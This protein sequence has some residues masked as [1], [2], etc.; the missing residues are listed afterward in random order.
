MANEE[1]Q[2]LALVRASYE[3]REEI[4][5][6]LS[7]PYDKEE[8]QRAREAIRVGSYLIHHPG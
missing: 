1:A 5:K 2:E 4:L 6:I 7:K 8:H 3:F